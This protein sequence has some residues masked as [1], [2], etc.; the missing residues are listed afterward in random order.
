MEV[1][2]QEELW[3]STFT[4]MHNYEDSAKNILRIDFTEL[5]PS[6]INKTD[7]EGGVFKLK[8]IHYLML[9]KSL[10]NQSC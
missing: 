1:L 9:I 7:E 4:E 5:K 6:C 3:E 8:L 10:W 2:L